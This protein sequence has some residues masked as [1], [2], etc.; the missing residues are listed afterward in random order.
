MHL[1]PTPAGQQALAV[2]DALLTVGMR[3]FFMLC[4]GRRSMEQVLGVAQGLGTKAD[5]VQ[6]M[7]ELGWLQPVGAHRTAASEQAVPGVVEWQRNRYVE[8]YCWARQFALGRGVKGWRLRL[9][10]ESATDYAQLASLLPRIREAV[11][12]ARAAV[13]EMILFG[14]VVA[15]PGLPPGPV[16]RSGGVE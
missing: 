13:L 5:D 12:T 3:A 2:Q 11:G 10:L 14:D 4:D 6:A 15:N 7:L 9:A 8:G 1:V 16:A